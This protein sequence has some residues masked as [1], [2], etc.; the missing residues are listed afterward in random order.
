MPVYML[1]E[2]M[3]YTEFQGWLEYFERRPVG[4]RDDLRAAKLM[5]AQGIEEKPENLF[6][7]LKQLNEAVAKYAPK[8]P[9]GATPTASLKSSA[10]FAKLLAAK[11]GDN[12]LGGL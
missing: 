9:E 3:P 5:Q 8:V 6:E 10:L 11:G 7:S 2:E 1:L 4:W 12:V